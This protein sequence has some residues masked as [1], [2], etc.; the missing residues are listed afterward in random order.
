MNTLFCWDIVLLFQLTV[1]L[2]QLHI[3]Y[4]TC[5]W[6]NPSHVM[7]NIIIVILFIFHSKQQS[8]FLKF[9][10]PHTTS[11][12]NNLPHLG[13]IVKWEY[14]YFE[15]PRSLP[16]KLLRAKNRI[17]VLGK[18]SGKTTLYILYVFKSWYFKRIPATTFHPLSPFHYYCILFFFH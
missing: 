5:F 1:L 14:F 16:V 10:H 8:I 6:S 2:L 4:S 7:V 9:I 11:N 12:A 17:F 3:E 13:V 18:K 15:P